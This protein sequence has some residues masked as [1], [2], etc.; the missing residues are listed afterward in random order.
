M[1]KEELLSS[2]VNNISCFNDVTEMDF[3]LLASLESDELGL[4]N[5]KVSR[6]TPL[7]KQICDYALITVILTEDEIERIDSYIDE[8]DNMFTDS[9]EIIEICYQYLLLLQQENCHHPSVLIA[10]DLIAGLNY[11]NEFNASV[12][13][14]IKI[15]DDEFQDNLID[16]GTV[17]DDNLIEIPEMLFECI[18]NKLSKGIITS[19]EEL[20]LNLSNYARNYLN[21]IMLISKNISIYQNQ[22]KS[23]S[24]LCV[25]NSYVHIFPNERINQNYDLTLI[26]AINSFA[27][28]MQSIEE[29]EED[30]YY[31][32]DS[33]VE[34][35]IEEL[36]ES[37]SLYESFKYKFFKNSYKEEKLLEKCKKM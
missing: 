24:T 1:K 22:K 10:L 27:T 20:L 34:E 33:E 31:Q 19:K 36:K 18:I 11:Y 17:V 9:S 23:N 37:Y 8:D 35:L 2:L 29:Y 16:F 28:I 30:H 26:E 21:T 15:T 12:V 5:D 6:I 13:E 7:L 25:G 3:Y 4:M 32:M 14:L